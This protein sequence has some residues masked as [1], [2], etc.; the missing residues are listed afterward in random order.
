MNNERTAD[1]TN[2]MRRNLQATLTTLIERAAL[3][4]GKLQEKRIEAV[5]RE[6]EEL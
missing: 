1:V 4:P 3:N 2:L 5:K 6:I